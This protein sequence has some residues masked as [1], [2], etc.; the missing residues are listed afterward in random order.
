MN[1]N[2]CFP[3][4]LQALLTFSVQVINSRSILYSALCFYKCKKLSIQF[5][6]LSIFE[7]KKKNSR[8][9]IWW[10]IC[11]PQ[12]KVSLSQSLLYSLKGNLYTGRT[13]CM[14]HVAMTPRTYSE[15]DADISCA[16]TMFKTIV[17]F[18][19]I[20]LWLLSR[21]V[22]LRSEHLLN[23]MWNLEIYLQKRE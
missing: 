3:K 15:V 14:H 12:R 10:K 18:K 22:S 13:L 21:S 9:K 20:L 19:V 7:I 2:T 11:H 6:T 8:D 1:L 23:H 17:Y 16:G 4:Y 5:Q